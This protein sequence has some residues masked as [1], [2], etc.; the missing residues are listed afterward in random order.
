MDIPQALLYHY[1]GR[2]IHPYWWASAR[3]PPGESP[4]LTQG[5][6]Y[7]VS[8]TCPRASKR[9]IMLI[10]KPQYCPLLNINNEGQFK[11]PFNSKGFF[12]HVFCF[13]FP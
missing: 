10:G 9:T 3:R 5:L 1:L 12:L 13:F 11:F 6:Q 2:S 7:E 8:S 4:A